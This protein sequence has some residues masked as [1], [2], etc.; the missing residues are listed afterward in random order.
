[1]SRERL[2]EAAVIEKIRDQLASGGCR[3]CIPTAL[4]PIKAVAGGINWQVLSHPV[5]S[6]PC[7]AAMLEACSRLA[8]R[9]DVD[10][11]PGRGAS[12][13]A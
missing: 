1:M 11:P 2:T 9:Y 5:C 8:E 4:S 12:V 6:D 13:T 10:W 7:Q 3:E